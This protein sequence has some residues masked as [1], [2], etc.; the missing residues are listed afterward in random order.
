[1][2]IGAGQASK[3]GLSEGVR[4]ISAAAGS[5]ARLSLLRLTG[6]RARVIF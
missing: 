5:L 3:V 1:M 2:V 4:S 6:D